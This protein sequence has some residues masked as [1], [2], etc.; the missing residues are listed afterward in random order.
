MYS[1]KK[2]TEMVEKQNITGLTT[3][4]TLQLKLHLAICKACK[5]YIRQSKL[6]DRFFETKN[7]GEDGIPVIENNEL[8]TAI[9]NQIENH[10]P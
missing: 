9:I 1:C 6:I 2:A 3:G 8:K 7:H 5:A 10:K 4:E